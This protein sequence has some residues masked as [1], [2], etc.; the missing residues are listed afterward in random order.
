M[1]AKNAIPFVAFAEEAR[2]DGPSPAEPAARA[3]ELRLRPVLMTARSFIRGVLPLAFA[4]G[5]NA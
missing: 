3:G 1:S 2:Q 5:A 4:S